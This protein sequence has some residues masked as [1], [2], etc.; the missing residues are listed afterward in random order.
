MDDFNGGGQE[1]AC[2]SCKWQERK[3][4]ADKNAEFAICAPPHTTSD[5]LDDAHEE[6]VQLVAVARDSSCLATELV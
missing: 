5:P 6:A 4:R 3:E 2:R 1:F